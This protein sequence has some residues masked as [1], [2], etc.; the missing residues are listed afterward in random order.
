ML[1]FSRALKQQIGEQAKSLD[2]ACLL[3]DPVAVKQLIEDIQK[4]STDNPTSYSEALALYLNELHSF[5]EETRDN[6]E[7]HTWFPNFIR[8]TDSKKL[9]HFIEHVRDNCGL[10]KTIPLLNWLSK[11]KSPAA[12]T[13]HSRYSKESEFEVVRVGRF[14]VRLQSPGVINN[15]PDKKVTVNQTPDAMATMIEPSAEMYQIGP[16]VT[17]DLKLLMMNQIQFQVFMSSTHN[18]KSEHKEALKERK[19]KID[20]FFKNRLYT[21][22]NIPEDN[23]TYLAVRSTAP[24]LPDHTVLISPL[25][26]KTHDV[27][28]TSMSDKDASSSKKHPAEYHGTSTSSSVGHS[29]R[30]LDDN[31]FNPRA[32]EID[33]ESALMQLAETYNPAI[34]VENLKPSVRSIHAIMADMPIGTIIAQ[35]SPDTSSFANHFHMHLTFETGNNRLP[36]LSAQA[37]QGTEVELQMGQDNAK[38]VRMDFPGTII[39]ITTKGNASDTLHILQQAIDQFYAKQDVPRT[40]M[41]V[42]SK[43]TDHDT[44]EY[45]LIIRKN[46]KYHPEVQQQINETWTVRPQYAGFVEH[47][48]ALNIDAT[49]AINKNEITESNFTKYLTCQQA[50]EQDIQAIENHIIDLANQY[51]IQ[52]ALSMSKPTESSRVSKNTVSKVGSWYIKSSDSPS[53]ECIAFRV[54]RYFGSEYAPSYLL[55]ETEHRMLAGSVAQKE[56]LGGEILGDVS[57]GNS[58]KKA[59]FDNCEIMRTEFFNNKK[60]KGDFCRVFYGIFNERTASDRDLKIQEFKLLL[61]NNSKMASAAEV[62][63]REIQKTI[64]ERLRLSVD[65]E[66]NVNVGSFE[67]DFLSLLILQPLDGNVNNVIFKRDKDGKIIFQ[68]FDNDI[69]LMKSNNVVKIGND[70]YLCAFQSFFLEL[71]LCNNPISPGLKERLTSLDPEKIIA[72]MTTGEGGGS[73]TMPQIKVIYDRLL[74]LQTVAKSNT[75]LTYDDIFEAAYPIIGKLFRKLLEAGYTRLEAN[76]IIEKQD[77]RAIANLLLGKNVLSQLEFSQLNRAINHEIM[78]CADVSY[79]MRAHDWMK[80]LMPYLD[81]DKINENQLRALLRSYTQDD[82]ERVIFVIK[83]VQDPL[84]YL[85]DESKKIEKR[86]LMDFVD[87]SFAHDV[88]LMA[89]VRQLDFL[90]NYQRLKHNMPGEAAKLAADLVRAGADKNDIINILSKKV[91]IDVKQEISNRQKYTENKELI[92]RLFNDEMERNPKPEIITYDLTLVADLANQLNLAATKNRMVDLKLDAYPQ[93]L[94]VTQSYSGAHPH[95]KRHVMAAGISSLTTVERNRIGY[96]LKTDEILS[97]NPSAET[98]DFLEGHLLKNRSLETSLEIYGYAIKFIDEM[99]K[100]P[101]AYISDEFLERMLGIF[102][103]LSN[104]HKAIQEQFL[105]FAL[106]HKGANQKITDQIQLG[107]SKINSIDLQEQSYLY[108]VGQCSDE[109]MILKILTSLI[110]ARYL[111]AGMSK[112]L[113]EF[114]QRQL[115]III[116]K[117]HSELNL[118]AD[119]DVLRHVFNEFKKSGETDISAFLAVF[120]EEIKTYQVE[121][122]KHKTHLDFLKDLSTNPVE[123]MRYFM[124]FAGQVSFG[125]CNNYTYHKFDRQLILARMTEYDQN[126]FS[127]FETLYN[128]QTGGDFSEQFHEP[129]LKGSWPFDSKPFSQTVSKSYRALT[130]EQIFGKNCIGKLVLYALYRQAGLIQEDDFINQCN[131]FES[132]I[133]RVDSAITNVD[134]GSKD[135]FSVQHPDLVQSALDRGKMISNQKYI[136]NILSGKNYSFAKVN[137]LDNNQKLPG[138]E[139]ER[140]FLRAILPCPPMEE[141][142]C[143]MFSEYMKLPSKPGK[144]VRVAFV[145]KTNQAIEALRFPDSVG[146]CLVSKN[147]MRTT[148]VSNIVF[149]PYSM[150]FNVY[151]E[152]DKIIGHMFIMLG[153]EKKYSEEQRIV[154][155]ANQLYITFNDAELTNKIIDSVVDYL[156]ESTGL[157]VY[158]ASDKKYQVKLSNEFTPTNSEVHLNLVFPLKDANSTASFQHTHSDFGERANTDFQP[159]GQIYYHE[160]PNNKSGS[161]AKNNSLKK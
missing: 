80:E 34:H 60:F 155:M 139:K 83:T 159:Q 112:V 93:I 5:F 52:N 73:L 151:G 113:D 107:V 132:L 157:D 10:S 79:Y 66:S 122:K 94:A 136:E 51:E 59:M 11:E 40:T 49:K 71:P 1:L 97:F 48:G 44:V 7:V 41:G 20:A 31:D 4:T 17:S 86:I 88:T 24:Y 3:F 105:K 16:Y 67:N 56:L 25:Q 23:A 106:K 75:A 32:E 123:K 43:K 96:L 2:T 109:R 142:I 99:I 33:I 69:S 35:N 15:V 119:T 146:S 36:L 27:I 114:D 101:E 133:K 147:L 124:H 87:K 85:V 63:E 89:G 84:A 65:L 102:A 74:R 138:K 42:V 98:L 127:D 72:L 62:F 37:K 100:N 128:E 78:S 111:D 104:Q 120:V 14:E 54:G 8:N 57:Q 152:H 47:C 148:D 95:L 149:N 21:E 55:E 50:D 150:L 161:S 145:D 130:D 29:R 153:V 68:W 76:R 143:D 70:N 129:L 19:A 58:L 61:S 13:K 154:L 116:K 64:H 46:I 22:I 135:K 134:Q 38:M 158:L 103:H 92:I 18:A 117:L 140:D 144:S 77:P 126:I 115:V 160:A 28:L 81:M 131:D 6:R 12:G 121:P 53:A 91:D 156:Q 110:K 9:E 125:Y 90:I 108:A 137:C 118:I 141:K 82:F 45:Y 39:R 30:F 26:R